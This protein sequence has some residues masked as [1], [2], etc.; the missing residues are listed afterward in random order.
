MYFS[1]FA[2][3]VL[4]STALALGVCAGPSS[5]QIIKGD[6]DI[7]Q[8]SI[9]AAPS[10]LLATTPTI[11]PFV[12]TA[13]NL[14]V[15]TTVPQGTFA[16][17]GWIFNS[18]EGNPPPTAAFDGSAYNISVFY[19]P[20]GGVETSLFRHATLDKMDFGQRNK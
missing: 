8:G 10:L 14:L 4:L 13:A 6:F 18:V 5:P 11:G 12:P 3:I 1:N 2:Q 7:I 15:N 20:P 16:D 9:P 19:T 17:L